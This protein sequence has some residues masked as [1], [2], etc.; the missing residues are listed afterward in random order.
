MVM[1]RR[2]TAIATLAGAAFFTVAPALAQD[3]SQRHASTTETTS[4]ET[5][6]SSPR[7]GAM[8]Q[9]MSSGTMPGS[10]MNQ[11]GQGKNVRDA[12]HGGDR[13]MGHS[14]MMRMLFIAVDTDGSGTL[15]LPEVQEF[16]AR[17]FKAADA[18]DDGELT[19]AEM[20]AIMMG[21]MGG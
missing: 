3:S 15:S 4:P 6:G 7:D 12:Q 21:G 5:P 11:V 13:R 20:R 17:M 16:H 9:R 2:A 19:P 10:G 14:M 1:K 8:M 18:D